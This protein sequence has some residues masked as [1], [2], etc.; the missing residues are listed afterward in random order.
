MPEV[1]SIPSS[2]QRRRSERLSS[3][4][5]II[6]RGIDLLGQPFEERTS[7]L[8]LNLHGC[9]Y[10]SKHH[11]PKNTWLTL[12]VARGTERRNLRAR[13]AW[14]QRPH[15][16]REFF[17]IAIELESPGNIWGIESPPADWEIA[18]A[19]AGS[20]AEFSAQREL[21]AAARSETG[22]IS[23]TTA[24]LTERMTADMTNGSPES[25]RTSQAPSAWEAAPLAESPL[26]REWNAELERQ[27]SRAVEA[28]AA[29][30][31]GQIR[32][33]VEDFERTRT[34]A[35]ADFSAE[36]A[37]KQA[38]LLGG[39]RAE[40]ER[41]LQQSRELLSELDRKAQALRAESEA[42]VESASRLAQARLH[43]EAAE[44]SR[45][46][47]KP[48]EPSEATMAV[49]D[50]AVAAW[51]QRL[52]SEMTLARTQWNE[53][54]QSSLDS[55]MERLI[56]QLSAQSQEILRQSEQKMSERVAELR[57]PLG[58]MSS[59]A[60]ETIS[61][62]KSALEE[63][64]ARA[65]SSLAEI[66][67]AAG[68][69]KEYSNQLEAASHDTL[70]ELHRRLENIL[71]AQ[72]DEMNRRAE[73]L[74]SGLPQRLGPT[75][76][77]AG[78]QLVERTTAEIESKIAP[79]IER[80]PELLRELA[81]REVEAEESLRLHRERLRQL[82]ENNQRE[83]ALQ[84][85]ATLANLRNDFECA[86][87]EALAKW[88]EELDAAGVRASH[89]AAESIGRSSEWFQQEAR[90]HLQV[91]VEQALA[92][93]ASGFEEKTAQAARKF[94]SQLEEQSN[95]RLGQIRE[96]LG[97]VAG[98]VTARTRTQLDQAAEAAAASFGEVVR[99]I[100]EQEVQQFTNTSRSALAERTQDLE[101][102][103]QQLLG[104]LEASAG[105]SID[106]F[107]AQMASELETSIAQGRGA[108]AAEFASALDGYRAAREAQQKTWA[109][110]LER[111]SEE[112]ASRHQER[113]QTAGDS[114]MVSSVRRLNEHGQNAIESLLR[115]ADQSLRE[116]FSRVFEGLSA[117][118]RERATNSAGAATFST[119]PNREAAEPPAPHNESAS[120]GA[121]A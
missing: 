103:T 69:M 33:I 82:S 108:L 44:A 15:S 57:Q 86:R 41:G 114:W 104:R 11:L 56:R 78:Q 90:A 71:G 77:S 87:T 121:N 89:A 8:T 42:A 10:S 24:N 23:T 117:M 51:R 116:S 115:S 74:I 43:A 105:G 50:E 91:L 102:F 97:G 46:Q 94:E 32:Q 107:R 37:A 13:V 52:E 64:V 67:R 65:R 110:S 99:S 5:P 38:E 1:D 81:A 55:S 29:Q 48:A 66:E 35:Q 34:A 75:L 61:S 100:S 54:L 45:L 7:T 2:T 22:A 26:W 4:V 79:R 31:G 6:V 40:F 109:E 113:L 53:L 47:Q 28:A 36:V 9:R 3:S 88:S 98:E 119:A 80:V 92:G 17:Q 60:Q 14:I 21:Q 120:N 106:R 39:L 85:T 27:A 118:L 16:V 72:T 30:A 68:R 25:D 70:N 58:Q 73:S 101:S 76:D 95:A 84:A 49:A 19:P 62:V 93:A 59:E 111:A 63:E 18:E 112:A 96:Q 83:M 20:S 12:E